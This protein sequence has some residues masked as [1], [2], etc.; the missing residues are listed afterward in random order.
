MDFDQLCICTLPKFI[1]NLCYGRSYLYRCRLSKRYRRLQYYS[2][3]ITYLFKDRGTIPL[4]SFF[5]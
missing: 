1:T 2:R 4:S 5:K 3:L